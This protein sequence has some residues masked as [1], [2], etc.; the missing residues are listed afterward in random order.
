MPECQ[1]SE[2][3]SQ[4]A[5]ALGVAWRRILKSTVLSAIS[6][7][8]SAAVSAARC[9]RYCFNTSSALAESTTH[10][11]AQT[12]YL[13]SSASGAKRRFGGLQPILVISL[14]EIGFVVRTARFVAHS[15][16]PARSLAKAAACCRSSRVK[17]TVHARPLGAVASIHPPETLQQLDQ[18]SVGLLQILVVADDRAVFG[19]QL[20]QFLPQLE[21]ILVPVVLHGQRVC[22]PASSS[23]ASK[24]PFAASSQGA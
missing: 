8:R 23:S 4:R 1:A 3:S 7:L 6:V 11:P 22:V 21:R 12:R 10:P 13:G 20:A 24:W 17:T 16:F 19:H 5:S 9:R 14:G 2:N 18:L 15:R